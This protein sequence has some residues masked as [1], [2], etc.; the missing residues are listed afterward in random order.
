MDVLFGIHVN[1]EFFKAIQQKILTD[2]NDEI[3][4]LPAQLRGCK[5]PESPANF[6]GQ[7][8]KPTWKDNPDALLLDIED[9]TESN[10]GEY[11]DN[12]PFFWSYDC[13]QDSC[14]YVGYELGSLDQSQSLNALKGSLAQELLEFFN[15]KIDADK[16]D[17]I[18]NYGDESH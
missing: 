17:F 15:Y 16:V 10:L 3:S 7:C 8:G 14:W 18:F 13:N 11:Y 1:P 2:F 6:C 9:I 12:Y 4:K 5:H